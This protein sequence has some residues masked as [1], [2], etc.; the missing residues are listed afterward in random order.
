MLILIQ[1]YNDM[2]LSNIYSN[3]LII[4]INVGKKKSDRQITKLVTQVVA[5]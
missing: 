2:N 3:A 5:R 1:D 4:H